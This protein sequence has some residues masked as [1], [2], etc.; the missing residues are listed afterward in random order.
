MAVIVGF[1]LSGLIAFS[2]IV[3]GARFFIAPRAAATSYGV[4]IGPGQ[5]GGAYLSVKGVRDIASGLLTAVVMLNRSAPLL[6]WF[7]V[8]ATIIPLTDMVIVYRHGGSKAA[9]FGI[10]GATALLMLMTGLLLLLA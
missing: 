3:I 5:S 4:A 10:H 9:A 8:T 7:M 1:C 2:I 6:G